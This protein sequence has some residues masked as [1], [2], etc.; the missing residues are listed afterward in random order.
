[1][2]Q[3]D[4]SART[5]T[6]QQGCGVP[7]C[8]EQNDSES[9][10]A[11]ESAADRRARVTTGIMERTGITEIMIERLVKT[12]YQRVQND[13]LIGPIFA[14]RITNWDEHI[15]K[16]C[17]FWSSVALMSGRYHGQPMQRHLGLPIQ[18]AHFDRWL[19]LFEAT[20]RELCPPAAA[21]HFI[22]RARRIADS[23]E[24]GISVARGEFSTPRHRDRG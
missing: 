10:T 14:A 9:R 16:L 3:A 1:M 2:T 8:T 4:A 6:S 21:T 12:F 15:V 17:E 22:E 24:M 11:P 7:G 13:G 18:N 19:D 23:L 20:A 5:E